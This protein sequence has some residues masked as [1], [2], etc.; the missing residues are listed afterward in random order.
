MNIVYKCPN[1]KHQ[2][3]HPG[4]CPKHNVPMQKACAHCGQP[5]ADCICN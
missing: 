3:H 5:P 2:D 1:C 4:N